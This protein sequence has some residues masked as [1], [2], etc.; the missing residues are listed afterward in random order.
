M[1]N[2]TWR[3]DNSF[4]V[5]LYIYIDYHDDINSHVTGELTVDKGGKH[6]YILL[7]VK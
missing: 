5:L 2:I 6:L 7:T 3:P 4:P 1:V